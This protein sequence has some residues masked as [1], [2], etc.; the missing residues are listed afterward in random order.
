MSDFTMPPF[1]AKG[2]F[3]WDQYGYFYSDC[4]PEAVHSMTPLELT[5]PWFQIYTVLEKAKRGDR[6]SVRSLAKWIEPQSS[7]MLIHA[8]AAII[9]DS[10]TDLDL[11][12][13]GTIM[14]DSSSDFIRLECCWAF[15]AAGCLWLV[16]SMLEA[17][18]RTKRQ[19]D[20]DSISS[21]LSSLLE[22]TP[23]EIASSEDVTSGE[24]CELIL[25]RFEHLRDN[26]GTD[27]ATVWRGEKYGVWG[28]AALMLNLLED[29]RSNY[30]ELSIWF[31]VLR[32]R[33]ESST[34][35]NCS[36]FYS[37]RSFRPLAA[38][39][40]LEDFLQNNS[41]QQYEED[42]RYFFGHRMMG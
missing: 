31:M 21:E 20:R 32:H 30:D 7:A 15:R 16:P 42:T 36:M 40:I 11:T 28:L 10:G 22:A 27:R 1:M 8:C 5:N 37:N 25:K 14:L 4:V 39:A 29:E 24:Y 38:F 12:Q 34:G 9:A 41:Q 19:S 23:G 33:F 2:T 18:R 17:W 3:L 26:F 35:I 13:L 6:S